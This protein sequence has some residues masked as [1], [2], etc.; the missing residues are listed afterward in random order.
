MRSDNDRR[1][2]FAFIGLFFFFSEYDGI[3]FLNFPSAAYGP[4]LFIIR[5]LGRFFMEFDYILGIS[6]FISFGILRRTPIQIWVRKSIRNLAKLRKNFVKY[7]TR[8]LKFC[9]LIGPIIRVGEG[10]NSVNVII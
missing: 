10:E 1:R 9:A 4:S 6:R 2:F 8:T 5:S 7:T 3:R